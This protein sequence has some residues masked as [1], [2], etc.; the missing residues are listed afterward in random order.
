MKPAA[1]LYSYA[2]PYRLKIL[3]A[4]IFMLVSSGLNVL[5]PY[6]FKSVVDDVLI[7]RNTLMLNIICVLVIVIFGIKAGLRRSRTGSYTYD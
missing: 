4:T 1:F 2:K 7:S 5:P 3:L 6:L